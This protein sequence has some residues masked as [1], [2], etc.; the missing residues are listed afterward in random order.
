LGLSFSLLQLGFRNQPPKDGYTGILQI[1][2]QAQPKITGFVEPSRIIGENIKQRFG[3][4][5]KHFLSK[6]EK[7]NWNIDN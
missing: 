3:I 4:T 5:A 7:C 1:Y 6:S 2:R